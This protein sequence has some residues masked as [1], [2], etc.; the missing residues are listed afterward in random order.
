MDKSQL[1]NSRLPRDEVPVAG[2]GVVIVR[3]LNR[4]EAMQVSDMTDSTEREVCLLT[5]G[6][7]E[8]TFTADEIRQ[9]M[10]AAPAGELQE[11]SQRIG[12]LSGLLEDSS[13]SAYKSDGSGSDD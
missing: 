11:I 12:Q 5:L 8:P 6:I 7:V 2:F 13:K 10:V 9:W 3:S 1:F 4:L